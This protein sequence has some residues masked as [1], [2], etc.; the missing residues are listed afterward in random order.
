VKSLGADQVIDYTQEDFTQSGETYDVIIDIL[1]R[2]SFSRCT[3]L[4]AENGR[5]V[6]A[7][8]KMRELLQMLWTKLSGSRK[9]ICVMSPQSTH[10]LLSVKELIEAGKIKS[11][12]DRRY[13]LAQAAEA[14]RY[15]E[16]GQKQGQVVIVVSHSTEGGI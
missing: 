6:R 11:V 13:P 9:V 10:Q 4:L 7:S 12:I 15:V 2:S 5:Y 1:G 8:W 3:G 14:H 16:M